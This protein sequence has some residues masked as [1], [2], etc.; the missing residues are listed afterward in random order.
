MD[1]FVEYI[2]KTIFNNSSLKNR[3]QN[4]LY[5]YN[6][7]E[8]SQYE[9]YIVSLK[10]KEIL[11]YL[12]TRNLSIKEKIDDWQ[13]YN[14][15]LLKVSQEC[16]DRFNPRMIYS[17]NDEI[18]MVFY[19]TSDYPD[20]YNGNVNKTLTTMSSFATRQ[21]TKEFNKRN[22]D[23]EFTINAKYAEFNQ[24]YEAL[25][26]L[27]WRQLDCKRNN[28]I[29]LFKYFQEDVKYLVLD[30]VT[31]SLFHKLTDLNMNY[32]QLKYLINGNV[33]KKELVYVDMNDNMLTKKELNV[34]ND[35]LH[36]NFKENLRKYIYNAYL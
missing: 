9:P 8:F 14:T 29:T 21:F 17:F 31:Q 32:E 24:E 35:L 7:Q 33:V 36:E 23:F 11:E 12:N 16:Y 1:A 34:S 26:Y 5:K 30:D 18:H 25:N 3:M 22:L 28:I 15:M 27:V 19:N 6:G 20:L 2:Q 13:E 4:V 10:S